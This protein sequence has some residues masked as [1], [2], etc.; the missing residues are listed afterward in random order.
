MSERVDGQCW[1]GR[2]SSGS[3]QIIAKATWQLS[4]AD[5]L[6]GG[7]PA[8]L[9]QEER[10]AKSKSS[11]LSLSLSIFI[12]PES[13]KTQYGNHIYSGQDSETTM[14]L[15]NCSKYIKTTKNTIASDKTKSGHLVP[16]IK[17]DS[18]LNMYMCTKATVR[19]L[20]KYTANAESQKTF[21]WQHSHFRI[22]SLASRTWLLRYSRFRLTL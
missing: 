5:S 18:K 8:Y 6:K 1:V 13:T 22:H 12:C 10:R 14:V 2:L 21:Y 17:T 15:N 19:D 20:A 9:Q 3:F 4:T 7:R 11:D 16:E